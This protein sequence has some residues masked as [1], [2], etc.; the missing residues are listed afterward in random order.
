MGGIL[1]TSRT[2]GEYGLLEITDGT[3]RMLWLNRF[4]GRDSAG[5]PR[6]EV[7]AVLRRPEIREGEYLV[8]ALCEQDGTRDTEIFA[9]VDRAAEPED[10]ERYT[11]IRRAWRADLERGRIEEIPVAGITCLNEAAGV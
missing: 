9:I 8:K 10:V 3:A 1:L 4:V 7:L 11:R 5:K 2:G 6:W